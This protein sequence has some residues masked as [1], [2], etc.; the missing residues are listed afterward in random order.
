MY[1]AVIDDVI[2]ATLNPVAALRRDDAGRR[3]QRPADRKDEAEGAAIRKHGGAGASVLRSVA[4][5]VDVREMERQLV[6]LVASLSSL[7]LKQAV[8][9]QGSVILRASAFVV[10]STRVQVLGFGGAKLVIDGANASARIPSDLFE[11]I[12]SELAPP[13][14]AELMIAIMTTHPLPS[15][16]GPLVVVQARR[17][18]SIDQLSLV[19]PLQ[20]RFELQV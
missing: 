10:N 4:Q 1:A 14:S 18:G 20:R 13:S 16:Y 2:A 19:F 17:Y 11:Q 8:D 9:G 12:D 3:G 15:T 6:L 5:P 7:S